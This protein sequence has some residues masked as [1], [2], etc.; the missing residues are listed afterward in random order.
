MDVCLAGMAGGEKK[1]TSRGA[2]AV[3]NARAWER[4]ARSWA[5]DPHALRVGLKRIFLEARHDAGKTKSSAER[6]LLVSNPRP[7]DYYGSRDSP[8]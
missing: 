3:A 4:A 7:H 1:T 2:A 6:D 5:S 8:F